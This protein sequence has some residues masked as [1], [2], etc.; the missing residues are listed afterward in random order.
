VTSCLVADVRLRGEGALDFI[1]DLRGEKRDPHAGLVV[2]VNRYRREPTD[3]PRRRKRTPP[4][5]S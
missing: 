5:T 3:R 1:A 2:P 4:P